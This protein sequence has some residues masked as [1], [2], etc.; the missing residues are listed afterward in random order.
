M[1]N[2]IRKIIF[3][4]LVGTVVLFVFAQVAASLMV[5]PIMERQLRRI[6]QVPIYMESAGS[7]LLFGS[8]WMKGVRIKN[9]E[10][11]RS[12]DFLSARTVSVNVN[13]FS[14]ITNEFVIRRILLK[15][16]VFNVEVNDRGESNA[17]QLSN[18]ATSRFYELVEKKPKL[19]RLITHYAIEK[20]AVRRGKINFQDQRHE[21]R[22]WL[23]ASV[24]FSL[25]RIVFPPD[26]EEA[27]PAAV[28]LNAT[29][30]GA[31]EGKVLLLG[32]L[33]P[34]VLKKSFD[35]TGSVK[36]LS[37]AYYNQFFSD[38]SLN[39]T[40]GIIQLKIK[41][42]CHEDQVDLYHQIHVEKMKISTSDF[43]KQQRVLPML[44]DETVAKF[45][46]AVDSM[47]EPFDFDF[48]VT[49]DLSDPEFDLFSETAARL[50]E[51]V[52]AKLK[53]RL[54][55]VVEDLEKVSSDLAPSSIQERLSKLSAN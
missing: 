10:G 42:L 30:P 33:N 45:L 21:E 53:E 2:W 17:S 28:Y 11:F 26:P 46:N 47:K 48:K 37:L 39:F 9:P 31:P 20:F 1:I 50:R 3:L 55:P 23:L 7:N 35:I 24:S 41:A 49:G 36:D 44:S 29:I 43:R 27:L 32:R 19:I 4:L 52:D 13:L 5:K 22:R 12:P 8:L 34:F 40:D 54:A 38:Y 18:R 16:P 25:A 51:T 14:F 6:F 15:D